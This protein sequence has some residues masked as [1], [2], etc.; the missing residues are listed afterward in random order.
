[1][2]TYKHLVGKSFSRNGTRFTVVKCESATVVAAFMRNQR[3]Q[4]MLVPLGDV[5]ASLEATER[6]ETLTI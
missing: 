4:R 3:V 6:N 5:L 2:N 1:M